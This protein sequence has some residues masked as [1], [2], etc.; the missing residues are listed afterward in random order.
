MVPP[1]TLPH[2]ALMPVFVPYPMRIELGTQAWVTLFINEQVKAK[3]RHMLRVPG[4]EQWVKR[5]LKPYNEQEDGELSEGGG[6]LSEGEGELLNPSESLPNQRAN[7]LVFSS[8]PSSFNL[9]INFWYSSDRITFILMQLPTANVQPQRYGEQPPRYIVQPPAYSVQ[10]PGHSLFQSGHNFQ[11]PMQPTP[12]DFAPIPM[13]P[14]RLLPPPPARLPPVDSPFFPFTPRRYNCRFSL[15]CHIIA[16]IRIIFESYCFAYRQLRSSFRYGNGIICIAP[17]VYTEPTL[18]EFIVGGLGMQPNL[19]RLSVFQALN[20][21]FPDIS[22]PAPPMPHSFQLV[23]L[24]RPEQP[25]I[26]REN[27]GMEDSAS[28]APSQDPSQASVS[29]VRRSGDRGGG[30]GENRKRARKH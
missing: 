9:L 12:Y 20:T 16:I 1:P 15:L 14:P 29:R 10:L 26:Q 7:L 24:F 5:C 13:Q 19:I 25:E 22:T 2:P 8:S 28:G 6:E 27:S 23:P 11:V 18:I 3:L 30:S 4:Y 21:Q 17:R